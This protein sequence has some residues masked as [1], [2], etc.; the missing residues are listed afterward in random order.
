MKTLKTF[1]SL[2]I[3]DSFGTAA[4][5]RFLTLFVLFSFS[6]DSP[7]WLMWPVA[8]CTAH[9]CTLF[10]RCTYKWKMGGP[11]CS[12]RPFILMFHYRKYRF[13]SIKFYVGGLRYK[14]KRE[15]NFYL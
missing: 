3:A 5:G 12:I 6:F 11:V 15:F 1:H 10:A 4:H 14:L 2:C 13:Y 9:L 7:S 8:N